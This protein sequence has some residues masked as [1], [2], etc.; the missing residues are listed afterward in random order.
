[1]TLL[2]V[3]GAG[4]AGI[5]TVA[6]GL[7]RSLREEGYSTAEID[8]SI[9]APLGTS[10]VW[11]DA[12]ST[13][14]VW[15]QSLGASTLAAQELEGLVGLNELITGVLVADAI[16]NS[17]IDVVVWDMGSSREALRTLQLLDT[18]PV[19]LDR[20]LTGPVAAQISAPD[21][22]A[23]I[24]A[25]YGLVTHVSAARDL[26]HEAQSV[27]VGTLNDADALIRASGAM[28]LYGCNPAAV[29]L[30]KVPAANKS[31]TKL[32]SRSVKKAVAV[33]DGI[34]VPVVVLPMAAKGEPKPAKVMKWLGPLREV[35]VEEDR[36]LAD[37]WSVRE[38]KK[39]Y[40]LTFTLRAG[41]D[42]QVGRRG[43]LLLVICDGYRR[44]LELP[45]VLKRCLITSGGMVSGSL[46]LKFV[47]D[48]KV[49]REQP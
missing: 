2:L 39:G 46:V 34:G 26:V 47:P 22:T 40:S 28:R 10:Q 19:L 16:R 32:I 21:P 43:D 42:V 4:G 8:S 36:I 27:L 44:Q 14:G 24:T 17:N 11:S 6:Q 12:V 33:V 45:A 37:V 13:F 30:N 3:S 31:D 38:T 49:W 23:L 41:A 1:M 29:V 35:L 5:T 7:A 9:A 48:P 18:V 25:W 20:L 15:L